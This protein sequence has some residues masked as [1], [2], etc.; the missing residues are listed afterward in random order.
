M[1]KKQNCDRSSKTICTAMLLL[2][3]L[4]WLAS[5]GLVFANAPIGW[6][7]VPTQ[8]IESTTGGGNGEI[9]TART[10]EELVDYAK[11]SEP[12]T[13]LVEGTL[14]GTSIRIASNKTILGVG[15]D[16]EVVGAEF[17]MNGVSNIIIRNLTISKGRDGISAR[18][19]HHLWIDHCDVSD[20]G[21]GAIDITRESDYATVS[22]TRL[23]N[24]HKTMLINGGTGH[25][26]DEGKLNTTV[27]HCWY[28]KS[29][30]RNP[31]V[32]YGEVH[33]FNCLYNGNGYCI[34]L[35]SG[36]L[37][38]AERNYFH[39][40]ESPIRQ[41]YRPDPSDPA[42]G[43][44]ESVDN[45]F[46]NCSGAQD[47][48]GK[49]FPVNDYYLYDFVLDEVNDVP[50]IVKAK[51]GPAAEFGR[52]MPLPVPGHGAID[53]SSTGELR[54]TKG[55]DAK[56]YQVAFG[57]TDELSKTAKADGQTFKP[58]KLEPKTVYY[59]RVDQITDS[60]VIK[61]DVW[62]FRTE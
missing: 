53:V 16:A 41:M 30:T 35:H 26:E 44:C 50:A 62:R 9:V 17:S 8:G 48:E 28:D 21:D 58:G 52:P 55:L 60:G 33:I 49:S 37:V 61:G 56:S 51:A 59:W 38:R 36:C 4:C 13:I 15:D 57:K 42:H 2:A 19:S 20:C 18:R 10:V 12:L 31:R 45:V 22:W 40:T 5:S 24:H 32:G 7:V 25:A 29:Q 34:G 43:F 14:S 23:S 39:E 47:D 6:A 3:A 27:H 54:W 11:R 46:K 1:I